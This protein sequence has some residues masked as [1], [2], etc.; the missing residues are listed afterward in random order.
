LNEVRRLA[1]L[2]NEK[3][4]AALQKYLEYKVQGAKLKIN[5]HL[6]AISNFGSLVKD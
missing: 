3:A 5:S 4:E 1:I 6:S 2:K